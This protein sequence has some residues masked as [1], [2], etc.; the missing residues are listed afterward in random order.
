MLSQ[1]EL[2]AVGQNRLTILEKI[3]EICLNEL[4]IS[5]HLKKLRSE[6]EI[7]LDSAQELTKI[8]QDHNLEVQKAQGAQGHQEDNV[9]E[10]VSPIKRNSKKLK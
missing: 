4:N 8:L 10:N 9:Y 1:E 5:K 7:L 3:A 6:R 2:N